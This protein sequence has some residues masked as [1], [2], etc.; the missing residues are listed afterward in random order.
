MSDVRDDSTCP[1]RDRDKGTC[2]HP[3]CIRMPGLECR[4]KKRERRRLR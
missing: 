1:Y 2:T 4:Y 3:S